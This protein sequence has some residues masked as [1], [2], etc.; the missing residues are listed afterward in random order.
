MFPAVTFAFVG[1]NRHRD[2]EPVD[3]ADGVGREVAVGPAVV[4]GD[5][6]QRGGRGP[7][8]AVALEAGPAVAGGAGEA[9]AGVGAAGAGPDA[10]GPVAGGPGEGLVGEGLEAEAAAL[11]DGVAG[12]GLDRGADCEGAVVD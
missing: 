3:E 7:A 1:G 11:E 2:V 10:A 8:E 12:V 5:L 6:R 4:E 9:G